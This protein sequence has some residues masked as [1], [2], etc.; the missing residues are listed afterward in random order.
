VNHQAVMI[1]KIG[2]LR[3]AA[4]AFVLRKNYLTAILCLIHG[5]SAQYLRRIMA[6]VVVVDSGVETRKKRPWR[7]WL[8][9]AFLIMVLGAAAAFLWWANDVNALMP[10]ALAALESSDSVTVNR[11][12]WI[13]FMPHDAPTAGLIL[14]PGGKV[15]AEAYAP[16]ARSVAEEG[17]LVV[18]VYAPLNLAIIN[19]NAAEPVQDY[20]SAVEQW[21]VGGHSLGGV[22]AAIYAENHLDRIDGLV[23]LAAFPG[24]DRLLNSGLDVLSLYGSNDGLATPAM[25]EANRSFLPANTQYIEIQG[26]NHG[27]FGY[28]GPQDGD[29]EASISYD[30]QLA[31]TSLAIINFLARLG[32]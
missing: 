31:Q 4:R 2:L 9:L 26:G 1:E 5:Q 18:I 17:Y 8:G 16:L 11:D 21:A 20:F 14:Y 15:Q 22:T 30:E 23:L 12:S 6:K 24:D 29:G 19:P 25:V 10:E 13:S 27:Q 32:Q 7:L 3:K 28:Y